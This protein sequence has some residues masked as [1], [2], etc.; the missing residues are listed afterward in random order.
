MQTIPDL[1]NHAKKMS[2][3]FG[4]TYKCEQLFSSM[5]IT[6][7]KLRTKLNDGYWQDIAVIDT[8]N[9]TPA[10]HKFSSQKQRQIS[11]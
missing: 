3:M 6:N 2:S 9:L 4:S 1:I 11:H 10:H 8:S 7:S 5:K